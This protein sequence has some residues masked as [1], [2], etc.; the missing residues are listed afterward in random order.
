MRTTDGSFTGYRSPLTGTGA[1]AVREELRAWGRGLGGRLAAHGYAG[2]F[3]IDALLGDDGLVYATESNVRR[4]ATTTP[5]AMVRRLLSAADRPDP[6][7]LMA[8]AAAAPLTF[9]AALALLH[10]RGLAYDARH[11]GVVLFADRP[12]D[13][14]SWRYAAIAADT[15]RLAEL[16]AATSAAFRGTRSS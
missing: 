3:G 6:A 5:H 13:G 2:H 1:K 11:E 14:I 7:W 10:G 4:T 15:E 12:T 9:P 8:K 16:E